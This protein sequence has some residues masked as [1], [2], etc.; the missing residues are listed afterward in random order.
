MV[1]NEKYN[2]KLLKEVIKNISSLGILN[3]PQSII[4]QCLKEISKSKDDEYIKMI[5][6][7]IEEVNQETIF[8]QMI[9]NTNKSSSIFLSL[10][11]KEKNITNMILILNK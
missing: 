3:E 7:L 9:I 8:I 5:E 11:N 10:D 6:N 2:I 1:S 4:D